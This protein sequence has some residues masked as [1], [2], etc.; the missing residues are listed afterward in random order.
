[1]RD[2]KSRNITLR[3]SRG[4]TLF[5]VI[6]LLLFITIMSL[7]AARYGLF[8][9]RSSANDL[10]AK[11]ARIAADAGLDEG[12]EYLNRNRATL[13]AN[14]PLVWLPCTGADA[15]QFPC[16]AIEDTGRRAQ[17]EFFAGGGTAVDHNGDGATNAFDTR[18]LPMTRGLAQ[19]GAFDISYG[20]GVVRCRV[21]ID[22]TPSNVVCTTDNAKASS[23]VA[24]TLVSRAQVQGE[25]STS[26]LSR[27]FGAYA[28]FNTTQQVPPVLASGNVTLGGGLQIVA[29]P[30][31]GGSGVPV[32]VWTR[33]NMAKG[34]TPNTCY[35][36]EFL[37]DGGTSTGPA[38]LTESEDSDG[39]GT[40]DRSVTIPVCDTCTCP[41]SG[42]LSYPGSGNKQCEG[43]DVL[44]IDTNTANDACPIV[45]N[46]D[47]KRSEF[48][49]DLFR[50]VF[51]VQAWTDSVLGAGETD[52]EYNFCETA[53]GSGKDRADV[54]YLIE[55][56]EIVLG[57]D[58]TDPDLGD[59]VTDSDQCAASA[60][61]S[62]IVWYRSDA[63]G[64]SGGSAGRVIGS[65]LNPVI[66]VIDGGIS[67]FH[68]TVYGIV[69]VRATEDSLDATTGGSA[70]FDMN[71]GS[72]IYGTV[73]IQGQMTNNGGGTAAI[74]Y[75][76]G[77]LQALATDP[78]NIRVG[79]LPGSWTDSNS[80]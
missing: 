45:P 47:V 3:S 31:G 35:M 52:A 71:A 23:T 54:Q 60:S 75:Q 57:D 38:Y 6:M 30:N 1:M 36:D 61:W 78:D 51:G 66:L 39:D 72:T 26:T 49:C 18:M 19:Q 20:V 70:T 44:D 11:A 59:G 74:V 69:F 48:P 8:E 7:F 22:S 29:N 63:C 55:N 58:A 28:L 4:S 34:G 80:Y 43:I 40:D 56:A 76:P 37:R 15:T 42:A 64:F 2:A 62:G 33:A 68:A 65:A 13:S 32:S 27:S 73:V 53:I 25:E 17:M 14:N 9:T 24:M 10:R 21:S 79:G 16:G 77:I 41:T 50:H 67:N 46:V 12:A 5:V